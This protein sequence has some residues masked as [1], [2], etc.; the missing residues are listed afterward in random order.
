MRRLS[1]VVTR[2]LPEAVETR[3][4]EL[5]DVH[6]R[7]PDTPMERAELVQAMQSADVLVPCVGDQIDAGLIGQAG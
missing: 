5:F 4:K 7:D 1:V 2:R 6:L 3:M